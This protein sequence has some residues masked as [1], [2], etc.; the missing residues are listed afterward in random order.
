MTRLYARALSGQRIHEA[1]PGG[2][3]KITTSLGAMSL[4]RAS[5]RRQ[6]CP[7]W[8]GGANAQSGIVMCCAFVTAE[9][10]CVS[11]CREIRQARE[12]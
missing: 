6:R 11:V 7:G 1:M 10:V 2:D 4:R 12:R 3:W 9:D 5:L 8:S